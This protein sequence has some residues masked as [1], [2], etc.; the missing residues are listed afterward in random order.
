MMP[1]GEAAMEIEIA[2]LLAE[3]WQLWRRIAGQL[4]PALE[5]VPF[6][7]TTLCRKVDRDGPCRMRDRGAAARITLHDAGTERDVWRRRGDR[8][9]RVHVVDQRN[10][11][12]LG[13]RVGPRTVNRSR[14]IVAN[15]IRPQTADIQGVIRFGIA[16]NRG[17]GNAFEAPLYEQGSPPEP[18]LVSAAK[19]QVCEHGTDHEGRN[20]DAEL[21][22]R[23]RSR[24]V[25]QR[26]RFLSAQEWNPAFD[27]V[28]LVEII[29]SDRSARDRD[30]SPFRQPSSRIR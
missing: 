17:S 11:G 13:M 18:S 21:P 15:P 20:H 16:K 24:R 29:Q 9:I 1:P 27:V 2:N 4:H 19:A 3:A 28:L 7:G 26:C 10:V 12:Q 5:D 14:T 25:E 22:V 6:A 8:R 23:P 30:S